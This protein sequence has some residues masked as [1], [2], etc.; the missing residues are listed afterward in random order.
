MTEQKVWIVVHVSCMECEPSAP[1]SK[2]EMVTSREALRLRYP[3]GNID[4]GD[5]ALEIHE[6]NLLG[7]KD[8][9]IEGAYRDDQKVQKSSNSDQRGSTEST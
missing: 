3:K 7:V 5:Y 9:F 8:G 1:Y 2:V 4:G 6:V